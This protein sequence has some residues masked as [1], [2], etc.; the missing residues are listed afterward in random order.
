MERKQHALKKL[1]EAVEHELLRKPNA[2][3][4]DR[5]SLLAGFQDWETFQET[6]YGETD[7]GV[8]FELDQKKEAP[9]TK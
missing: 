1:L 3:T 6:L 4:L 9:T 2:K 5:L 7:G 8:N